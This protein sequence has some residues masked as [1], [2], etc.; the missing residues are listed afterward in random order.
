MCC[1][2]E[3]GYGRNN[4]TKGA[5][6]R[7]SLRQGML[8]RAGRGRRISVETRAGGGERALLYVNLASLDT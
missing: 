3:G 2:S 1:A 8:P 7:Q 4:Q 6:R 5:T